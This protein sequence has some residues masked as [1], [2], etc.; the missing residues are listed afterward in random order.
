MWSESHEALLGDAARVETRI[1][2]PKTGGEK[3]QKLA[4]FDLIPADALWA[5]AEHY[6]R[7]AEKYEDRNWERGYRWSLSFGALHRHLNLLEQGEDHD[8]ETGTHHAICVAWHALVLFVFWVRKLGTD[9][10]VKT[11]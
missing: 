6:G 11:L 9:D 8:K 1:V 2:D 10:R 3:G 5:L 7:G 4:R